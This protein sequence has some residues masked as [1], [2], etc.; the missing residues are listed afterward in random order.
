R[1]ART[2]REPLERVLAE[3]DRMITVLINE[4]RDLQRQVERL[5]RQA[6]GAPSAAADRI[7]RSLQRRISS[8][9]GGPSTPRRRSQRPA[10]D[11]RAGRK[12][13]DPELLERRRQAL[14]KARAARAAK[15]AGASNS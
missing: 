2:S 9:S 4:N 10:V 6:V 3:I 1:A 14:V 11:S 15:R 12:I 5:N 13:T 7:L 8:A